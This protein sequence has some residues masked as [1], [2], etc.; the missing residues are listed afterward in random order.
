MNGVLNIPYVDIRGGA[1][2]VCMYSVVVFRDT[3][4]FLL[5]I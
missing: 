2:M 3:L 1:C 4:L 5:F